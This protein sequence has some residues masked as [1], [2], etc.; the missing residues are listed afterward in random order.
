MTLEEMEKRLRV[1]E[2]TEKIKQLQIHYVNCLAFA[3]WDEVMDC[4]AEDSE[5]IF[6]EGEVTKGKTEI[7][8]L[9]REFFS[10]GHVGRDN[11]ILVHP[12]ITVDG[13]KASGNWV[14]YQLFAHRRTGQALFWTVGIYDMKY[15]KVNGQWKISSLKITPHHTTVAGH[16][17]FE[18]V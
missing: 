8:K 4:F 7:D 14:I 12:L 15:V 6:K 2:D 3:K 13:D 16:A 17:P 18:G 1:V 11:D 5:F 9:F 10:E